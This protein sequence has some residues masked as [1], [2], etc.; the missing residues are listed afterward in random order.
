[1]AISK[2]LIIFR[3]EKFSKKEIFGKMGDARENLNI[4]AFIFSHFNSL[5]N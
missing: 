5:G 3:L 4:R 1:M 2:S